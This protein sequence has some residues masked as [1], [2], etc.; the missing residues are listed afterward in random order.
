MTSEDLYKRTK[1]FALSVIKFTEKLPN[2]YLGNHIK[3][4]LIRSATSVAANYRAANHAQTKAVFIAKLSIVIEE[5]DES[6]FWLEFISDSN[7]LQNKDI[8]GLLKEAHELTS[9][10]SKSRKTAMYN[11]NNK[12]KNKI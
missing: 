10:F 11:L 12:V 5:C 4:Q 1:I 7:L 6:E 8:E 2:V 9:I 3:G